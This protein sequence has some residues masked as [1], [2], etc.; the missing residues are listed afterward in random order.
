MVK[1]LS[2]HLWPCLHC[3]EPCKGGPVHVNGVGPYCS[4]N[5]S[6]LGPVPQPKMKSTITSREPL[7][8]A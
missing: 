2:P 5:C 8:P 3:D 6:S 7:R 4:V 1:P